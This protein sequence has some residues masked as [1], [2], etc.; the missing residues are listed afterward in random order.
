MSTNV[1]HKFNAE[2]VSGWSLVTRRVMDVST[3][4][5]VSYIKRIFLIFDKD[6]PY[7]L[8]ITCSDPNYKIYTSLLVFMAALHTI[9][10][11]W[12]IVITAMTITPYY[13]ITNRYKTEQDCLDEMNEIHKKQ[14]Q[15]C[16]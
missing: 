13:T 8:K 5:Q 14:N 7:T 12:A 10:P 11:I 4:E 2:S 9:P 6:Y 3:V 15:L 16:W 1:F